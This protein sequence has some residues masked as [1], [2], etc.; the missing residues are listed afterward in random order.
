MADQVEFKNS[1]SFGYFPVFLSFVV[2]VAWG[3]AE[4][5]AVGFAVWLTATLLCVLADAIVIAIK[6]ER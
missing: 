6:E 4:G 3:V 2:G 5:I 1:P